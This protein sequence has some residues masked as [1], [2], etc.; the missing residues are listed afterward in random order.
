MV[1]AVPVAEATTIAVGDLTLTAEG[2]R[3]VRLGTLGGVQLLVLL[4][5][6]H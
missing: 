3:A 4:R 5:H 2:G 1:D 6:R